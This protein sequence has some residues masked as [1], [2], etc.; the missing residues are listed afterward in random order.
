MGSFPIIIGTNN[1]EM[2]IDWTAQERIDDDDDKTE[3][4]AIESNSI[5]E[6]L[7]ERNSIERNSI[8]GISI[9]SPENWGAYPEKQYISSNGEYIRR[10]YADH[11]PKKNG[12]YCEDPN[13]IISTRKHANNSGES[14]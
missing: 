8:E 13:D 6:I 12:K 7:I 14:N 1:Y 3:R 11:I 9:D 2:N 10:P 5:K 4:I